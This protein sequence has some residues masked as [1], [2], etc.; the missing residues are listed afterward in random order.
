M[1]ERIPSDQEAATNLHMRDKGSRFVISREYFLA[2]QRS[3]LSSNE[4][5][6]MNNKKNGRPLKKISSL[7]LL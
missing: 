4:S 6:D 2:L 1:S 3:L 5:V 7:T